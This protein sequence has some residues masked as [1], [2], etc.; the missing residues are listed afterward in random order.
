MQVRVCEKCNEKVNG[1][2]LKCPKCGSSKLKWTE[3]EFYACS[4]C[5]NRMDKESKYCNICGSDKIVKDA[6]IINKWDKYHLI[7]NLLCFIPMIVLFIYYFKIIIQ[8]SSMI[9]A[10]FLVGGASAVFGPIGILVSL[11]FLVVMLFIS[12]FASCIYI[13]LLINIIKI[14]SLKR[15]IY[16]DIILVLLNIPLFYGLRYMLLTHEDVISVQ[17]QTELKFLPFI[18]AYFLIIT[19]ISLVITI[20]EKNYYNK[21]QKKEVI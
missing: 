2:G 12:L 4:D 10:I 13:Y 17:S 20:V 3:V 8:Y 7:V 6:Y 21:K 16:R 9:P 1:L 15:S 18:F 14:I 19:I 11:I 5:R